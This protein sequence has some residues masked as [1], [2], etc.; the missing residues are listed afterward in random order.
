ML[1]VREVW[2][3]IENKFF[4]KFKK[5]FFFFFFFFNDMAPLKIFSAIRFQIKFLTPSLKDNEKAN[6]GVKI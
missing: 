2:W 5:F 6:H 3:F 4:K 1:V